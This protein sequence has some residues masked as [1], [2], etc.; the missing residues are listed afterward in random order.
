MPEPPAFPPDDLECTRDVPV[1]THGLRLDLLRPRDR[2]N[3]PVPAVL[4]FHGGGWVRFAKHAPANVFLALAGFVTLGVDHR[5]APAA[6]FPAQ[7]EDAREAMAWLAARAGTP[8][9]WARGASRPGRT[10]SW[11]GWTGTT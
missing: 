7:L 4:H 3:E 6:T 1:G 10:A 11:S 2:T 9:A 8:R 5:L